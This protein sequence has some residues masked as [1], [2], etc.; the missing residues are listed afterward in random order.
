M[1]FHTVGTRCCVALDRQGFLALDHHAAAHLDGA[2]HAE[3]FG[4]AF[5]I[6]AVAAQSLRERPGLCAAQQH[7]HAGATAR[8]VASRAAAVLK[9][10]LGIVI[11]STFRDN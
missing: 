9:I 4:D 5:G 6:H 11:L 1:V 7:R 8:V 3:L 10:R 2:G